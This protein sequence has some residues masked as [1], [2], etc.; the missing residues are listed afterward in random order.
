MESDA[1]IGTVLPHLLA[2][3]CMPDIRYQGTA[4]ALFGMDKPL[5]N[6]ILAEYKI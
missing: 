3:P 6:D 5:L 4:C 2:I 1:V